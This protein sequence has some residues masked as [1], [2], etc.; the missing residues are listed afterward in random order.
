MR[1]WILALALLAGTGAG[2]G[3]TVAVRVDGVPD[4]RGTVHVELCP[5]ALFLGDCPTWAEAPAVAGTTVVTLNGVPPGEYAAQAYQ[6][7]NRNGRIDRGLFGIPREPIGFSNDAPLGVKGPSFD[8]ARFR[9]DEPGTSIR[10]K[11]RR[12]F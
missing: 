8:R 3:A 2:R 9:V 4:A 7:V 1:R 6:D 5:R 12:L 10:F 11:L